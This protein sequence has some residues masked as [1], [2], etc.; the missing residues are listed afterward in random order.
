MKTSPRL[1]IP[2]L[3][4][5]GCASA[6]VLEVT[7]PQPPQLPAS[8]FVAP[9]PQQFRLWT[10]QQW[11]ALPVE[12]RF[13]PPPQ[14]KLSTNAQLQVLTGQI[15]RDSTGAY[16]PAGV[17]HTRGDKI[18]YHRRFLG[19]EL[20]HWVYYLGYYPGKVEPMPVTWREKIDWGAW[21]R[22]QTAAPNDG[23]QENFRL[24]PQYDGIHDRAYD[25]EMWSQA[26]LVV[27]YP[28]GRHPNYGMANP[29]VKAKLLEYALP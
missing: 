14:F 26:G 18:D 9:Y 3:A 24:I 2:L 27:T 21:C 19:H 6:Q 11:Q 20:W 25:H 23:R 17:V 13:M 29:I 4:S 1:V 7:P 15:H 12:L 22:S 16:N 5:L 10:T 28:G 8:V